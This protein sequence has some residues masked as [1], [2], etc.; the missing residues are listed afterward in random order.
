M[1]HGTIRGDD[2]WRNT[3]LQCCNNVVTIRNNVATLCCAKSRR[4]ESSRV[5][6][7]L[8]FFTVVKF[9]VIGPYGLPGFVSDCIVGDVVFE[10]N[11]KQCPKASHFSGLQFLQDFRSQCP[12]FAGVQQYLDN[13]GAHKSDLWAKRGMLIVPDGLQH[14]VLLVKLLSVQFWTVLQVWNLGL[15]RL[16][17]DS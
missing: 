17:P 4:C 2:F 3:A 14:A 15:W 5:T 16:R 1:I 10:W 6:S 7:P 11:V 9:V 8:R 12:G 13:Q